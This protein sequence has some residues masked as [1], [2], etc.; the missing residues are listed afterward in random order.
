MKKGEEK[1][2]CARFRFRC[3]AKGSSGW[4]DGMVGGWRRASGSGGCA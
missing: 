4:D 3:I 1:N 2:L